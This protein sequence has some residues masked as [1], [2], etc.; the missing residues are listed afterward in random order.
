MRRSLSHPE[1]AAFQWQRQSLLLPSS[2][3]HASSGVSGR[4]L[5]QHTPTYSSRRRVMVGGLSTAAAV[6]AGTNAT[7]SC[8]PTEN[9]DDNDDDT[10][11][12]EAAGTSVATPVDD[13]T[14]T[15]VIEQP[16]DQIILETDHYNGVSLHLERLPEDA[17]KHMSAADFE[18]ALHTA[19]DFWKRENRKGIWIHLGRKHADKVPAAVAAG[20][21]FHMVVA[22]DATSA[23]TGSSTAAEDG[24]TTSRASSDD[25]SNMLILKK[26]LPDDSASRLP[27]G[28]NHQVGVGCLVLHPDDPSRMLTVQEKTGPAAAFGLW[29]MPTGLSDWAEDIHQA[30]V[31]ELQEETGLMADFDGILCLRQAHASGGQRT[32][33]DLFFVCRMRLQEQDAAAL[34]KSMTACPDEIAA[35]QWMSVQDY[36]DQERWQQSPVYQELNRAILN[37]S[38][39]AHFH[40]ATLPLGFISNKTNNR[41]TNTL[42]KSQL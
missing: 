6:T 9:K 16:F 34:E 36:C 37:A 41:G 30:A 18:T 19:L 21:S 5:Q 3:R 13:P 10:L 42:Y 1:S 28:P 32:V 26:W 2:A 25:K 17:D 39:H 40:H 31:R 38:Q 14:V 15:T 7:A 20:F 27:A 35:M 8:S 12:T 23:T 4:L 11:T 33:S 29:K 22:A 24:T